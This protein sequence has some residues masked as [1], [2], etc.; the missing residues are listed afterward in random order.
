MKFLYYL[1][2]LNF[3]NFQI[4]LL[5]KNI[6]QKNSHRFIFFH[7]FD[8]ENLY[9]IYWKI[10]NMCEELVIMCSL[11]FGLDRCI[12]FAPENAEFRKTD[13]KKN[14]FWFW[15]ISK[16]CFSIL[17]VDLKKL[18]SLK[19]INFSGIRISFS[20]DKR[21]GNLKIYFPIP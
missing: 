10:E 7:Y 14:W 5:K 20:Q 3:G 13:N 1:L 4:Y 16:V 18:K 15:R 2:C 19:V 8:Q 21:K 9:Y 17:L 6:Y 11:N 12:L